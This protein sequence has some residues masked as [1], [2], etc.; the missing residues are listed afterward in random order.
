VSAAEWCL[1][2]PI[3]DGIR[4]DIRWK[5]LPVPPGVDLT[6]RSPAKAETWACQRRFRQLDAGR[7]LTDRRTTRI[8]GAWWT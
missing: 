7:V 2:V 4:P 5:P 8:A 3:A 1:T 6:F